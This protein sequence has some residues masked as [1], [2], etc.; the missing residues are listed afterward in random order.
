MTDKLRVLIVDDSVVFRTFMRGC[1]EEIDGI[2]V[3]GI[4]RD[5]EDALKKIELLKPDVMT[6]D[7]E[8]PKLNGLGVLRA[9]QGN[10]SNI[11]TIIVS[12]VSEQAVDNTLQA[13]EMGA[14][15]CLVKPSANDDHGRDKLKA[16][17]ERE[18]KEIRQGVQCIQ[19]SGSGSRGVRK[20]PAA[21]RVKTP[22]LGASS[23]GR[24]D[25]VAIGSSTGGPAALQK[26]LSSLPSDFPVPITVTQHMPKLFL[27]TLA[28]RLET[29]TAMTCV[30]AEEGMALEPGVIYVAPGDQHMEIV[31]NSMTLI[32]KLSDGP[33]VHHCRPAVDITFDSLAKLAPNTKTLA[34]V[35]TGMGSDGALGAKKIADKKG[36]VIAQDETSSVVWGMPGET[37]KQGAAHDVLPLDR[38]GSALMM[39]CGVKAG[40]G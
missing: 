23:S 9:L 37:V 29:T 39:H 17:L 16:M 31:K 26:V 15:D 4:A 12:G 35:L 22:V 13:L 7:M 8:M 30:L 24:P 5:G 18:F 34:V 11:R 6:L 28:T 2:D 33:K 25:L 10:I 27:A 40:K 38:V 14:F 36:H 32:V 19:A 21:T 1:L 3:V 20:S